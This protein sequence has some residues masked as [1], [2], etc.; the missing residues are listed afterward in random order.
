[1]KIN[2]FIN[3]YVTAKDHCFWT[4]WSLNYA[5][6]IPFSC[7]DYFQILSLNIRKTWSNLQ[8]CGRAP[9]KS[10]WFIFPPVY[11]SFCLW[12]FCQDL[13]WIFFNFLYEDILPY[14]LKIDK[15][16]IWKIVF[17]V[18][19]IGQMRQIWTQSRI[20]GILMM[21]QHYFLCFKWCPIIAYMILWKLYVWGKSASQVIGQNALHKSDCRIF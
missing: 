14:I 9:I 11:I 1:M 21:W 7:I 15:A 19:I 17:V 4:L 16:I 6:C 13:L 20:L 10:V 3:G 5:D 8:L 2:G 18:L 12:H